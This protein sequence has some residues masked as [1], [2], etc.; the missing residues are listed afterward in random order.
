MDCGRDVPGHSHH[1]ACPGSAGPQASVMY[2]PYLPLYVT[3]FPVDNSG[4][5]D[6]L[7]SA[8]WVPKKG[9]FVIGPG[10]ALMIPCAQSGGGVGNDGL[11][12]ALGFEGKVS[13][14]VG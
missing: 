11:L 2:R 12:D 6:L 1:G 8:Y 9:T 3:D 14:G 4:M 5:G 10:A 13:P 7:L